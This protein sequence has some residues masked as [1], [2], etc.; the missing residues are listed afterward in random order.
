MLLSLLV[1]VPSG[2]IV[3]EAEIIE[4]PLDMKEG[5]K[6]AIA[7]LKE[8]YLSDLEYEDPSIH[9]VIEKGRL[10]EWQTNYIT[11]R[12]KIANATQL[13]SSFMGSYM[14]PYEEAGTKLAKDVKA[15]LA[16]TGDSFYKHTNVGL[17]LR[18]GKLYR[19]K[20]DKTWPD[21]N[22]RMDVLLIDDQGDLH[23][24]PQ[25]TAAE[26][27]SFPGV[28]VN[29]FSFGP[30]LVIDGEKQTDFVDMENAINKA[31]QRQ[32]IAQTGPLEYLIVYTEGPEDEGSVGLTMEQFAS[33]V[34]SFQDVQNAYNLDGGSMSWM[35]FKSGSTE[36]AKINGNNP[37]RR[38]VADIIYFASAW[39]AE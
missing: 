21:T 15:V 34:A 30:G 1:L 26:V 25:A 3:A 29:G 20:C 38:P 19:N 22:R 18:Q 37:K 4:L 7:P 12:V 33:F 23:I 36:Y 13:R 31:A 17:A 35:V 28:I 6:Q 39:Q 24:L 9:V 27:D 32:C 5:K 2:A 11:V 14:N 8:G 10:E 16:I